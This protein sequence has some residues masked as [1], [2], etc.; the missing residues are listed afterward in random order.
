MYSSDILA[1]EIGASF[2]D[3]R[4]A[5][6]LQRKSTA[7][8]LPLLRCNAALHHSFPFISYNHSIT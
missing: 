8:F 5:I 2:T 4:R 7:F 3:G 6:V 1:S